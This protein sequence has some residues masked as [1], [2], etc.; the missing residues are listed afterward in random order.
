MTPIPPTLDTATFEQLV[1]EAFSEINGIDYS[2]SILDTAEY[3]HRVLYALQYLA[4]HGGGGGGTIGATGATG[5]AVDTSAFVQKSGDTMTGKLIAA[6]DATESK[7]NIGGALSAG[8][9]TTTENGDIWITNQ[10]RLAYKSNNVVVNLAGLTQQNTFSQPQSIGVTSNAAPCLNVGNTGG[11]EAAVFNAQGTSP[12]VRIT[13]TGTGE[14]LRVEDETTPDATAFVISNL[15]RVGIGVDPDAVVSISLDTTGV[16]FGDG[17]IQTT[18]AFGVTGATGATGVDGGIGSTGATGIGATGATG[19]TGVSGFDGA[20]GATGPAADT[21]SFV[22]K[23]GDTMTGKLNLSGVLA[24]TAPVNL[25]S[26]ANPTTLSGGDFWLAS[27]N[28]VRWR[29]AAGATIAAASTTLSNTFGQNQIISANTASSALRVTQTGTGEALRVE[30][31]A[32]PDATAFVISADGRVGIGVTPDATVSLSL[33]STGVKFNDGTIQTTAATGS[34]GTPTDVQVFTSSG[35][36]TK[37]VGAKS[38]HITTIA[39]GSGGGS[40]CASSAGTAA[41]G[42]GG[43]A[44][45]GRSF[46]TLDASLLGATESVTVGAGGTGGASVAVGNNGNNGGVGGSS[47]FG[48]WCGAGYGIVT[49]GG[50]GGSSTAGGVASFSGSRF[51]FPAGNGGAGGFGTNGTAGSSV[52]V[53]AGA[54]GGGGI[55]AAGTFIGNGGV[56]GFS[57]GYNTPTATITPAGSNGLSV[58]TNTPLGGNGGGGGNASATASA[59]AGGNGGIYG[60]GGGGGGAGQGFSSGKGGDGSSGIVVVT[61]YF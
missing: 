61:T 44:G 27:D 45:G 17:T 15:G 2:K 24:G 49:T 30:D 58:P 53:G 37:P 60:A 13:Q 16:K 36:W 9:P 22:Q 26:A 57:T 35:T 7:L 48:L 54:G 29:T 41:G 47:F 14:A 1:L 23:S 5:P 31:S 42:G 4:I 52:F 34:T 59:Q 43:G 6:A 25:G 38:V 28:I 46:V 40:G 19:A 39:G 3:R 51:M 11:R 56:G 50:G 10:N 20:T 8:S 18:A 33:D 55:N 21:S 12:A 32:N